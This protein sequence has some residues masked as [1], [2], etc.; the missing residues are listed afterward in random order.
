MR[1]FIVC[2]SIFAWFTSFGRQHVQNHCSQGPAT[3]AT[4]W[5]VPYPGQVGYTQEHLTYAT[6]LIH[7]GYFRVQLV[8]VVLIVAL[9]T[10]HTYIIRKTFALKPRNCCLQFTKK[11]CKLRKII[12]NFMKIQNTTKQLRCVPEETFVKIALQVCS[13]FKRIPIQ[14]AHFGYLKDYSNALYD[15]F[16]QSTNPF[17]SKSVLRTYFKRKQSLDSKQDALMQHFLQTFFYH[18]RTSIINRISF[19]P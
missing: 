2:S 1:I 6:L 13:N 18:L 19:I 16:F 17:V 3:R 5:K 9:E 11:E 7:L 15:T 10:H 8:D 14:N 4:R 12:N